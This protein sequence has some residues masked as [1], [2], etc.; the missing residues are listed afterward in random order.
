M[1][2][3][4]RDVMGTGLE[5]LLRHRYLLGELVRRDVLVRYRGA[6]LGVLWLFLNPLIMLTVFAYVFGH[7]FEARWP[8]QDD[9]V[10]FWMVLFS[11]LIAFNLFAETLARAPNAV[12]GHPNFVKK[13]IFPVEILPVVPLGAALVHAGFNFLVLLAALAWTGRLHLHLALYPLMLLPLLLLALGLSWFLGAWGVFLRDLNQIVPPFVQMLLFLSPVL[14]PASA[15][16]EGLRFL[17]DYNPLGAVIE[18]CRAAALGDAI[19][20][21]HWGMAL[22][23]SALVALGGWRFFEYSRDEFADVL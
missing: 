19:N 14:Y 16:P 17:Y 13:I 10:P 9:G 1:K 2:P 18:S 22:A 12:R 7:V 3:S 21:V 15:V 5:R 8:Q 23:V 4:A 20:W 6:L 11:G